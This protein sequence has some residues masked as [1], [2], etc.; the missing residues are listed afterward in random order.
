MI[1]I[2]WLVLSSYCICFCVVIYFWLCWLLAL[3]CYVGF[4]SIWR[5]GLLSHC[6][7]WA[8]HCGGSSCCRARTPGMQASAVAAHGLSSCCPRALEHGSTDVVHRLS[9]SAVRGVLQTRDW[10]HV[11]CL[12]R[13]ILYQ[14]TDSL[15]LSH[16]GSPHC[17]CFIGGS[18]GGIFFLFYEMQ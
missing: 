17:I 3:G 13:Q 6:H 16:Q 11:S 15:P 5:A 12:G 4:F 2:I 14:V 1:K 8:P 18:F 7:M 9:C 10:T